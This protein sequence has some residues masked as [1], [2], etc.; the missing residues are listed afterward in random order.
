[1]KKLFFLL[2]AATGAS[3]AIAQTSG[4]NYSDDSQLSRWVV[5]VNFLGGLS[6]QELKVQSTAVNYPEAINTRIGGL[7]FKNGYSYGGDAQIGFFFGHKRHFGVGTGVM[8]STMWGDAVLDNFHIEYKATD[9]RGD[10][11]RQLVTGY[12]VRESVT[13]SSFS[14]P[15]VLK[16][17]NRFS[18]HWGFTADAGILVNLQ[19]KNDYTSHA[20]FD[21]EAIYKFVHNADGSV[22]TVYDNSPTPGSND[23]LI[24]KRQYIKNNADGNVANYF[25]AMHDQGYNVALNQKPIN[26]KGSVDYTSGSI[27]F[28]AQP[29][30]NLFLSDKAAL[31][32]G[33]Y[34]IYQPEKHDVSNTYKLTGNP[35]E[36]GSVLNTVSSSGGHS[37][38]V[39]LG[40]RFF[41]G[42]KRELPP[43]ISSVTPSSPSMCG[44]CDGQMIIR[45]L[46]PGKQV[47]VDYAMNGTSQPAYSGVVNS[48]S[49]VTIPNLCGGTYTGIKANVGKKSAAGKDLVIVSPVL[50][51][52][53]N[54]SNPTSET[55]CDGSITFYGMY[56]GKNATISYSYNG[57][58]QPSY[59]MMA[60]SDRA[61]TITH[62]CAGSYTNI[63]A[64]SASCTAN[65]SDITLSAPPPPPPPP[66]PVVEEKINISQPILF[67]LNKAK[68]HSVSMPVLQEAAK[69]QKED[70]HSVIT[71]DGHADI[72]GP[73]KLNNAL[74]QKRA[75]AVKNDLIKMGADPKR[76]KAKGH[77]SRQPSQSNDTPEGRAANRRAVMHIE[78]KN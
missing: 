71:V 22:S 27:G 63:Q 58:P 72:T 41:L 6:S 35:G 67:E 64:T 62:L 39:N 21:Y 12:D 29:S 51:V 70:K 7:N 65:G 38:G 28:I 26:N 56:P 36:Y 34:Y 75:N 20:N 57:K 55:A 32:F 53:A 18:K 40:V 2:I 4:K 45:G 42:K 25:Q 19:T 68:V 9:S 50:Q 74:S 73:V 33:V 17:K 69:E 11:F 48:D 15:V 1:M 78:G 49:T 3:S 24:T 61:V 13:V 23:F 47:S 30:M 8:Y 10:V 37:Y 14:I 52:T 16:Y 60:G 77:G 46:Q 44:S 31:N 66:A 59:T 5:D 76:I 43:F 54:P